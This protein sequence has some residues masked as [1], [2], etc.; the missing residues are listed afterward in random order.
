MQQA[1]QQIRKP[2][3][4]RRTIAEWVILILNLGLGIGVGFLQPRLPFPF[5][6]HPMVM[7]QWGFFL[8]FV[9][10][11]GA[12][13]TLRSYVPGGSRRSLRQSARLLGGA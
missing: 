9:G 2:K 12:G 3:A 6:W 5:V 4:T 8:A 11:L 7:I 1:Q 10:Y 13:I